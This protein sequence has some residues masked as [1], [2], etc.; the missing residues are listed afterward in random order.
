MHGYMCMHTHNSIH[1]LTYMHTHTRRD[2]FTIS[3]LCAHTNHA[4]AFQ[5][6]TVSGK[7]ATFP[8]LH[9]RCWCVATLTSPRL[10]VSGPERPGGIRPPG[11]QQP[12]A[13]AAGH[14]ILPVHRPHGAPPPLVL[15]VLPWEPACLPHLLQGQSSWAYSFSQQGFP[16]CTLFG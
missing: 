7:D 5:P 3:S 14:G 6:N 13:A 1:V 9:A 11:W 15:V 10:V 16:P 8:V 12:A 2:I 4:A